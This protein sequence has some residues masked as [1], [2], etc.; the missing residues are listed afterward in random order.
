MTLKSGVVEVTW[1][2]RIGTDCTS[3]PIYNEIRGWS[4]AFSSAQ[5]TQINSGTFESTGKYR[6][7]FESES[8]RGENEENFLQNSLWGGQ[9]VCWHSM[10]QYGMDLQHA[11]GRPGLFQRMQF[12]PTMIS[13]VSEDS[14]WVDGL[15]CDEAGEKKWQIWVKTWSETR[16]WPG[17]W[18]A[19]PKR[20][21]TWNCANYFLLSIWYSGLKSVS[22][23]KSHP[24]SLSPNKTG[25]SAGAN[26][27]LWD[28][29]KTGPPPYLRDTTDSNFEVFDSVFEFPPPA[30]KRNVLLPKTNSLKS[31]ILL[32]RTFQWVRIKYY[33]S[34]S[35]YLRWQSDHLQCHD[36]PKRPKKGLNWYGTAVL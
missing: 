18:D 26:P 20:A 9:S 13:G 21:I 2:T 22:N 35:Q 8:G 24:Q 31:L 16:D 11:Q 15:I 23:Y 36:F 29:A 1:R 19:S 34:L 12:V 33:L 7:S 28:A 25:I 5:L 17:C 10:E 27:E 14:G 32:W 30:F 4:S 3:R 6:P